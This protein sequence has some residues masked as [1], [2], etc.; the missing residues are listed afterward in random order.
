MGRAG[1]P[2]KLCPELRQQHLG[3][4]AVH[5]GDR[6]QP[7]HRLLN[8]AQ[9]LGDL[10]AQPR[11]LLVEEVDVGQM[12]RQQQAVVPADAPGQRPLQLCPL[13]PQ[14]AFSQVRQRRRVGRALE[15][16]REH[17][18]SRHAHDV[19]G[20]A[21]HLE[22]GVFEHLLQPIDGGRALVDEGRARAGQVA[23]FALGPIRDE[24]RAHQSMLEQVGDPLGILDIR[25]APRHGLDVRGSDDQHLK[26]VFED[27]VDGLPIDAGTLHGHV[28]AAGRRQPL[29]ER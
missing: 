26:L 3:R 19:G 12:R 20:N 1:E 16:G 6:V 24:A 29:R 11:D 17:R 23:Q 2:R 13:R 21:G 10:G 15:N 7:L 4:V 25:L 22:V 27:V 5:P 28:R 18:P 14:P 9:A 8:G